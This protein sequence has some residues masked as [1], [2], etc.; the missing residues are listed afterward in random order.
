MP[1][2]EAGTVKNPHHSFERIDT[3]STITSSIT[4]LLASS[5]EVNDP[6][7]VPTFQMACGMD[8]C[9]SFQISMTR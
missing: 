7:M 5:E 9:Q 2:G 6:G 8:R 1:G 4:V 3:R